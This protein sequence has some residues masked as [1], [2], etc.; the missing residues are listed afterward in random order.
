MEDKYAVSMYTKHTDS[1]KLLNQ[2]KEA[3]TVTKIKYQE[4]DQQFQLE[5]AE[6][7]RSLATTQRQFEEKIT[8]LQRT[9]TKIKEIE[10]DNKAL[11][12]ELNEYKNKAVKVLQSKD[13]TIEELTARLSENSPGSS[14]ASLG[15]LVQVQQERDS[16]KQE[17][18]EMKQTNE[19]LHQTVS[20]IQQNAETDLDILKA[21]IQDAEDRYE[22]E[23]KR[24]QS[25]QIEF[26]SKT[27]EIATAKDIHEKTVAIIEEKLT[28]KEEELQKLRKQYQLK[29][30]G[31]SNQ[32]ELEHQ[33]T[34]MADHL[35][36]KQAQID[37]LLSEK[38]A[39][40]SRVESL[41]I[42]KSNFN[43]NTQNILPLVQDDIRTSDTGPR[44]R[45]IASLA[46]T[47][48]TH[49]SFV[50]KRV[51][52]AANFLDA[53]S[54]ETGNFLRRS[55]LARIVLF[56]YMFMLHLWVFYV[57]AY[58]TPEMHVNNLPS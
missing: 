23:K 35:M 42:E 33:I 50:A 43:R 1:D 38:S 39:L 31:S 8:E 30:A 21:Q 57:L 9:M 15:E 47:L 22:K 3:H 7:S 44:L 54:V 6:T 26:L 20:E 34:T 32:L 46:P 41:S 11:K 49:D 16:L 18:L 28:I 37:Q 36:H 58:V 10:I 4:L 55:P 13:K 12:Q 56:L 53:I 27:Q 24:V 19:H 52:K 25:L 2:E 40:Q 48:S 17:L 14:I 5:K 51:I 45:S 29:G